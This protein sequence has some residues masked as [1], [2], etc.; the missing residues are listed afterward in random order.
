MKDRILCS[1]NVVIMIR[2]KGTSDPKKRTI[3]EFINYLIKYNHKIYTQIQ[4]TEPCGFDMFQEITKGDVMNLDAEYLD[5]PSS[6]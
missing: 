1:Q 6:Y 4:S 5:C 3:H 2:W